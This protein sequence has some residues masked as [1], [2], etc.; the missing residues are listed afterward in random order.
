M[1]YDQIIKK[2]FENSREKF[3]IYVKKKFRTKHFYFKKLQRFVKIIS[4]K[5]NITIR[6]KNFFFK[7]KRDNINKKTC[8]NCNKLSYF[9]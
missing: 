9:V 3:K 1:L 7:I 6:R 5:L 4:I 2:K 8:Y